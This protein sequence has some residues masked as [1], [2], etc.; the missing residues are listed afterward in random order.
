MNFF[1][2]KPAII[3]TKEMENVPSNVKA[4]VPCEAEKF[5]AGFDHVNRHMIKK[6]SSPSIMS[7]SS[8]TI[9]NPYYHEELGMYTIPMCNE[10][11]AIKKSIIIKLEKMISRKD[12]AFIS[13]SKIDG[14][15]I[16]KYIGHKFFTF[17]LPYE[18]LVSIG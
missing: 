16:Y 8:S 17:D 1:K 15:P 10:K 18:E 9:M 3:L 6:D 7:S 12:L 11:L 5:S 2:K 4:A 14:K 13:L